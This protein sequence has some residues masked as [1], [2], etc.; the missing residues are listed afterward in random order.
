MMPAALARIAAVIDRASRSHDIRTRH[1]VI[2]LREPSVG[3]VLIG[4][5][6]QLVGM[7]DPVIGINVDPDCVRSIARPDLLSL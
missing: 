5:H 4:K 3:G 2:V 6:F 7:T 1:L